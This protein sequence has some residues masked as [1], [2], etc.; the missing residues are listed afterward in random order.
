MRTLIVLALAGAAL[1]H[2]E[3][4]RSAGQGG[5]GPVVVPTGGPTSTP[6]APRGGPTTV[7]EAGTL[8]GWE[9]WWAYNR[10]SFL[11]RRLRGMPTSG[12]PL[13]AN[14]RLNR[15]ELREG[16]LKDLM[17]EAL[18]DKNEGVRS[19]AA[20]A[21]G[22]F[23]DPAVN[24]RLER[25]SRF[26]GEG[27]YTVR[28]AAL[29][30]M[31]LLR[32]EEN[33]GVMRT[34]A[35]D[36]EREAKERGMCLVSLA[37]DG[38]GDSVY[39]LTGLL[40]YQRSGLRSG[41]EQAPAVVEEEQ[42]RMSAHLLGF[43]KAENLDELLYHAAM[44]SRKW[45]PGVQGL[46]ITALGRRGARDY[47][48]PLFRI[49]ADREQEDAAKQSVPIALGM[50]IR[51]DEE[52]QVRR[53]ARVV[54]D[55]RRDNVL[56]RFAV[57]ALANVGGE[58]AV[59]ELLDLLD[60][61]VFP[62]A[63]D[64][65]FVCLALGILGDRHADAAE[66][67]MADY[68]DARGAELRS[69]LALSLGLARHKPAVKVTRDYLERSSAAR[70]SDSESGSSFLAWGTLALGLHGSPDAV[71]DVRRVLG[72]YSIPSVRQN[73]AIALALLERGKATR[74]LVTMMEE[75]G[76][77]HTKAAA[78][79]ALGLLPEP[80]EEAVRALEKAYRNDSFPDA[81]REMAVIALGALVDPSPI[82]LSAELTRRYN[83]Y[84]RCLALDEIAS[85]L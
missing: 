71:A 5:V 4:G 1:G 13:P 25:R 83:Y 82:P 61:N 84:I 49:L 54:R 3:G 24:G 8:T 72:K 18:D 60:R 12:T 57:M 52:A 67:L 10:E 58:T 65:A 42:R 43:S 47:V 75:A 51:H 9:T 19:S 41:A 7:A 55:H 29:Y 35:G 48:E 81:V 34:I 44:G 32:L 16:R 28:E 36:K 21:L 23:G 40:R 30:A 59:E 70:G 50:L 22:K 62:N 64:R 46:A 77:A 31:G 69:V 26:P 15:K 80:N 79:M 17:L 6:T 27:W 37:L 85:Y 78:V 2:G 45:G 68:E 39:T 33:R 38:S 74:E 73:A 63:E 20:I 11:A 53:L 56:Q 66:R 14:D 76:T